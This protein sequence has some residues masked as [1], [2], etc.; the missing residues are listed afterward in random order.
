MNWYKTIKYAMPIAYIKCP[1]CQASLLADVKQKTTTNK[2]DPY[3]QKETDQ[4]CITKCKNCG[5]FMFIFYNIDFEKNPFNPVTGYTN[6]ITPE[7]ARAE[8]NKN[9]FI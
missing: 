4:R 1:K 5:Q 9:V 2:S 8:W 3:E 6:A 7:Q